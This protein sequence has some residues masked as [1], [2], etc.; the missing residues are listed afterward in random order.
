MPKLYAMTNVK[1]PNA[2]N[3]RNGDS[4]RAKATNDNLGNPHGNNGNDDDANADSNA[5][6]QNIQ[7][8]GGAETKRAIGFG[9]NVHASKLRCE[10]ARRASNDAINVLS[11][12]DTIQKADAKNV[13][14]FE[15]CK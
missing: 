5:N 14:M 10:I 3:K 13:W 8:V 11:I 15:R 9:W 7:A 4:P 1:R 6:C 2:D 12:M